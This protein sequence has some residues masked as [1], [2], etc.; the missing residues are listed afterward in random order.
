MQSRWGYFC[1]KPIPRFSGY[2]IRAGEIGLPPPRSICTWH[3]S[4][5][6]GDVSH[7]RSN[8]KPR[9]LEPRLNTSW[10]VL[11]GSQAQRGRGARGPGADTNPE[12]CAPLGLCSPLPPGLVPLRATGCAPPG[13]AA[14]GQPGHTLPFDLFPPDCVTL[15]AGFFFSLLNLA[16]MEVSTLLQISC[17]YLSHL[18]IISPGKKKEPLKC[19][20]KESQA[21]F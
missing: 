20:G 2:L 6:T 10:C 17:L 9:L 4:R 3:L 7:G 16:S 5:I 14:L 19:Q 15:W 12:N 13:K 21:G 1:C 18:I 8:W 11:Y